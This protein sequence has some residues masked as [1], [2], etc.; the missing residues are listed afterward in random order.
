MKT[1]KAKKVNSTENNDIKEDKLKDE[2]SDKNVDKDKNDNNET[3]EKTIVKEINLDHKDKFIRLY[4]EYENYRKRTAKEKID[5]ITNAS[6][7]LLK[8]ILPI[9]DDFER[10]IINNKNVEDAS[11]IKEGFELIYNKMYK[12][13]VNNGLKS[14]DS[15]GQTFDP[16]IHE[17]ITKIPSP[18]K[19]MKGKIIDVIEKGYMINE[20]VIRFA[21]VVVG[22]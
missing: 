4:S 21:K 22:E 12:T 5:I 10:A 13:L 2:I 1:N 8:D 6:E 14:M 20:K 7:N 9:I 17:A 11:T 16:D 3:K 19:K 15:K 18:S